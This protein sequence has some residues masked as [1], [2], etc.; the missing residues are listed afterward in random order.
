MNIYLFDPGN[1]VSDYNYSLCSALEDNFS[2]T[3]VTLFA[4]NKKNWNTEDLNFNLID[5]FFSLTKKFEIHNT[6]LRR[7]FKVIEY[8]FNLLIFILKVLK[9]DPDIIHIQWL[10]VPF[11]DIIL[12]YIFKCM[13]INLIYTVHNI[14]P[15]ERKFYHI[16][17][18]KSVYK[19]FD[20]L[21]IHTEGNK[22]EFISLF[23]DRFSKKLNVIPHG[24]FGKIYL[25]S[26][27]D[28]KNKSNGDKLVFLFFGLIREYKG[29]DVLLQALNNIKNTIDRNNVIF[30]IYGNPTTD[31]SK[32]KDIIIKNNLKQY[33]D[34]RLEF[35][36]ER[37]VADIF[38]SSDMLIL[39]YKKIYQSGVALL[40]YTFNLPLIVSD[41]GGISEI[42]EE[43]KS[44]F[45]FSRNDSKELADVLRRVI[46]SPQKISG[47]RNYIK[48]NIASKYSWDKISLKTINLYKN[49]INN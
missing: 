43:G 34:L 45:I 39:P 32:Y 13:G 25:K 4:D 29:L 48:N 38:Q 40:G 16:Y 5:C 24:D 23:G 30:K 28:K 37:E 2:K 33:L 17:L 26:S 35:I 3:E 7:I 15:H 49:F 47:M 36:P 6:I 22:K 14:L 27:G 10:P 21:I 8:P 41:I 20:E 1:F 11:L 31:F 42:V 19:I 12:F 18:Y 46:N 9:N 44:G